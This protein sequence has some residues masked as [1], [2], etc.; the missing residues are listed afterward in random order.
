M[1]GYR[2]GVP[3]GAGYGLTGN[4]ALKGA[5]EGY[6]AYMTRSDRGSEERIEDT[7]N[8]SIEG[9]TMKVPEME[10]GDLKILLWRI[11]NEPGKLFSRTA[12]W[13]KGRKVC[14]YFF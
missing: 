1:S 4:D 5:V 6:R 12:R 2:T 10:K 7:G 13:I 14:A 11:C 3:S 8:M 9:V